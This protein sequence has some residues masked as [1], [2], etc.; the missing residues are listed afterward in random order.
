MTIRFSTDARKRLLAGVNTL[1]DAVAVTLGP[2]GRNVCLAKTFGSP[3]ITKDGV[4]V[5]K[6]IELEDHYENMGCLL[7]R[8]VASKTSDDAGDGTTTAT[9]LARELCVAGMRLV[10][11]GLAPVALKR[12][13]D[14]AGQWVVE[15]IYGISLPVKTQQDIENIATV[16]ANGD[17]VIGKVIA[18]AVAKVG[19][20]GVVNIEDGK[21]T[22]T[23]LEATDGMQIPRGWFNPVFCL[24]GERQE[25]VLEN[26]YILVLEQPLLACRPMVNLLNAIVESQRPMIIIAPDFGG[27]AL[28][29]FAQ[30]LKAKILT[31]ILVKAPGFGHNQEALLLD[32][33]CLT[34]A[35]LVTPKTGVN[36]EDVTLE[37]LGSARMVR[38]TSQMTTIVDGGGTQE[39]IDERISMIRGE[40]S[41]TGSEFDSDK[42]RERM[43][44]LLGGVCVIKVGAHSEV[45]V[46][47]LKARME[48]ALFATQASID[49]G[50]VPGGG[51]SYLRAAWRVENMY[52]A[53]LTGDLEDP[54]GPMPVGTEEIAGFKLVLRACAAPMI[55]ILDNAGVKGEVW[56]ER[57]DAYCNAD[58]Q[59]E[60]GL[61][62]D[63]TDVTIK[64][65]F[66]AGIVDP[67]KVAR[68]AITNAIS[69]VGTLLTT[70]AVISKGKVL[71]PGEM[72]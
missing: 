23:V 68:C 24:D 11:A 67:A 13:M 55:Q 64:N 53:A 59:D 3:L 8:E 48:D 69:A 18:E 32:I 61:G 41:K 44:K 52:S 14:K 62:I 4:S 36:L 21:G 25:T 46:K 66:E 6:E 43:G 56:V 12:G 17:N 38:I 2:K 72:G 5:A 34:G 51:A 49:E 50:V 57:L 58:G 35:T 19:R 33:A 29:L 16:S 31:A 45:A 65:L 71:R 1:A 60:E 40:L 47:E 9:V 54:P 42:L 28:P 27:E 15:Q 20:D 10:E 39:A 30:N 7:V 26:P 37:Q 70:E 22:T 63:A